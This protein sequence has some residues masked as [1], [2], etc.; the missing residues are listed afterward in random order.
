MKTRISYSKLIASVSLIALCS[1]ISPSFAQEATVT[2]PENVENLPQTGDVTNTGDNKGNYVIRDEVAHR[3]DALSLGDNIHLYVDWS[4]TDPFEMQKG[5]SM[6]GNAALDIIKGSVVSYGSMNINTTESVTLSGGNGSL[7]VLSVATDS[8]TNPDSSISDFTIENGN[9]SLY[10]ASLQHNATGGNFTLANGNFSLTDS[11]IIM[12]IA[13]STGT[14]SFTSVSMDLSGTSSTSSIQRMSNGDIQITGTTDKQSEITLSRSQIDLAND[15]GNINIDNTKLYL[16]NEAKIYMSE[17]GTHDINISDSFLSLQDTSNIVSIAGNSGN[18]SL[19]NVSM[20]MGTDG[21]SDS[22]LIA[23][24]GTGNLVI[25]GKTNDNS[26]PEFSGTYMI[27]MNGNSGIAMQGHGALDVSYVV[28]KDSASISNTDSTGGSSTTLSFIE[29]NENSVVKH[30]TNSSFL[31]TNGTFLNESRLIVGKEDGSI[32]AVNMVL[33]STGDNVTSF[34]QN[35]A[36]Y[37]YTTGDIQFNEGTVN[38]GMGDNDDIIVY[39]RDENSFMHVNGGSVGLG[40]VIFAGTNGA[41]ENGVNW[42]LDAGSLVAKNNSTI[43]VKQ[44]LVGGDFN[45]AG[46]NINLNITESASFEGTFDAQGTS[47]VISEKVGTNTVFEDGS[48]LILQSLELQT[49]ITMYDL[50][51]GANLNLGNNIL[52]LKN[53]LTLGSGATISVNIPR[54]ATTAAGD[55]ITDPSVLHGMINANAVNVTDT[56]QINITIEKWTTVKGEGT[57]FKFIDTVEAFDAS[58]FTMTNNRYTFTQVDCPQ[59]NGLCYIATLANDGANATQAMGGDE[60]Q[61]AVAQAYLDGSAFTSGTEI[62]QVAEY[63][64][65]MSQS[66]DATV[67]KNYLRTLSLLAPDTVG[68]TQQT[69]LNN[70]SMLI[71]TVANRLG[72]P[73]FHLYSGGLNS[74]DKFLNSGFWAQGYFNHTNKRQEDKVLIDAFKSQTFGG[75]VGLD[76]QLAE[77]IMGGIGY[78][79]NKSSVK[80][81]GHTR[82]NKIEMQTAFAYAK[83]QPNNFFVDAIVSYGWGE[84]TDKK[85]LALAESILYGENTFDMTSYGAQVEAGYELEALSVTPSIGL[86]YYRLEQDGYTDFLGQKIGDNKTVV[87]TAVAQIRY[88]E[89]Y[90]FSNRSYFHPEIRI[91][92]TYDIKSDKGTTLVSLPNGSAYTVEGEQLPRAAFTAGVGVTF[93]VDGIGEF[94][95]GYDLEIRK[96]MESHTG[97]AKMK[98]YF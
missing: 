16:S 25:S 33:G 87:V 57:I 76:A 26:D 31:L 49:P 8:G 53:N 51:I 82:K 30:E 74:G 6:T 97:S 52:T 36:I 85:E 47:M 13:G 7:A 9:F 11:S 12:G 32:S 20:K 92:G 24:Q 98:I 23:Q 15:S 38:L 39:L 90:E 77:N 29:A 96:K 60:N 65:Q 42:K 3:Q 10:M 91:G 4:N 86:R 66:T 41:F 78:S 72:N 93:E 70:Q 67:Q 62:A 50:S 5:F 95:L 35:S 54:S 71:E 46:E 34:N 17:Q 18:I 59:G 28:M 80:L 45:L 81:E 48:H 75:A 19:T 69:A 56:A 40:N 44:F 55:V 64:D 89:T 27:E 88:G 94:S 1:F 43:T 63:L 61:I 84:Q 68:L 14:F 2:I 79:Y 58:K 22:A 73:S 83:Y 21:G 37:Q